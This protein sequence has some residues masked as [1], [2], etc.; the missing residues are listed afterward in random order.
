MVL[1]VGLF[2]LL[3]VDNLRMFFIMFFGLGILNL[4]LGVF[5]VWDDEFFEICW[6]EV[7]VN[8]LILVF[9]WD[10]FNDISWLIKGL[11]LYFIGF[12]FRIW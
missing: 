2:L 1:C 7:V 4:V 9:C 12:F 6:N 11:K 8:L 5:F 10:F 3:F